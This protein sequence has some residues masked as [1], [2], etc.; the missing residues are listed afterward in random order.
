MRLQRADGSA[1]RSD[2]LLFTA[3]CTLLNDNDDEGRAALEGLLCLVQLPSVRITQ[4]VIKDTDFA[5]RLVS[6]LCRL[7]LLALLS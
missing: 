4:F 3:L 2:F 1:P 7:G 6:E 5:Q